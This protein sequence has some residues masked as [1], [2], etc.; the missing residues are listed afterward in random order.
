MRRAAGHA[1][2]DSLLVSPAVN[3]TQA[4][5]GSIQNQRALDATT[6]GLSAWLLLLLQAPPSSHLTWHCPLA[7]SC[8]GCRLY[9]S[10][11]G[12]Y[13]VDGCIT[14]VEPD[15]DTSAGSR[16]LHLGCVLPHH[17]HA[18]ACMHR[19]AQIHLMLPGWL[20]LAHSSAHS[21]THSPTFSLA[22]PLL[23]L[24]FCPRTHTHTDKSTHPTVLPLQYS[25]HL[26]C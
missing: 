7:V 6:T 10:V 12:A 15:L 5:C 19:H 2:Y 3:Q 21:H 8:V 9:G 18:K 1:K 14:K 20:T 26:L 24:L 25:T 16:R 4:G 22:Q 23:Y 11:I 13:R 17:W